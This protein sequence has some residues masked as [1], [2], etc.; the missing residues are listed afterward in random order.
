MVLF[1]AIVGS[2]RIALI[3]SSLPGGIYILWPRNIPSSFFHIANFSLIPCKKLLTASHFKTILQHIWHTQHLL[4]VSE[5]FFFIFLRFK[6]EEGS[7]SN[8][9]VWVFF[10]EHT[11][12]IF[13]G[14]CH[15]EFQY[16]RFLWHIFVIRQI[17]AHFTRSVELCYTSFNLVWNSVFPLFPSCLETPV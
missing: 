7:E 3:L 6:V 1:R 11:V 10:L 5:T 8:F 17:S 15:D 4:F 9:C 16:I 2:D 14:H 12:S 13:Y